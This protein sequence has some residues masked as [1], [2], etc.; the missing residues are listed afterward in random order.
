MKLATKQK[1]IFGIIVPL[2]LFFIAL[3]FANEIGS[4]YGR[5]IAAFDWQSTWFV[6][7]IYVLLVVYLEYKIFTTPIR[8][9]DSA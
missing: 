5:G 3:N 6:W 8:P 7:A 4:T 9:K 2:V 1:T